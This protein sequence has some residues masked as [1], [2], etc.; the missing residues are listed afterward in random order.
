MKLAICYLKGLGAFVP[1]LVETLASD[2]TE[3]RAFEIEY[4]DGLLAAEK[5]ADL[6]WCEWGNGLAHAAA[7]IVRKP[8]VCR[9]HRYEVERPLFR[10]IRWS[11]FGRVIFTSAHIMER[12]KAVAAFPPG[13]CEI[14]P[15]G[16]DLAKFQLQEH[17]TRPR[18]GVVGYL[19]GRK[20]PGLALQVLAMLPDDAEMFFAG[21]P[22]EA[23][24][25]GYM[26]HL[27]KQLGVANRLHMDGW[28]K[29]V[30]SWWADKDFCL[31]A[32]CDEGHPYNVLEAMACG[33]RP[34]IHEYE[35]A[36]AQFDAETLWRDVGEAAEQIASDKATPQ[37]WRD[38]LVAR[39]YDLAGQRRWIMGI[40]EDAAEAGS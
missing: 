2:E 33:V 37:R 39:K 3:V 32:S 25:M 19:H 15:S 18:I 13:T 9:V 40:L 6:V 30:A 26:I 21:T 36:A 22:Q 5:W 34:V 27:A 14:V 24:W 8:K 31:S 20:Q 35:G 10:E 38:Y 29:D 12:A 16:V 7:Q 28:V 1:P 23:H 17:G 11:E 4:Q